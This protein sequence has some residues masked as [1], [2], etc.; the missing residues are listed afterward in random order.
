MV[1]ERDR[2]RECSGLFFFVLHMGHR[3]LERQKLILSGLGLQALVQ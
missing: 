1:R 3:S 2:E